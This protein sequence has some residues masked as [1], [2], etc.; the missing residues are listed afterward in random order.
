MANDSRTLY[1]GFINRG[2]SKENSFFAVMDHQ[3]ELHYHDRN[4]YGEEIKQLKERVAT[5]EAK[6]HDE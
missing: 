6:G 3:N 5:L 2:V 4:R 1:Q